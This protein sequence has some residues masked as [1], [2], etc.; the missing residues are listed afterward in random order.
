MSGLEKIVDRISK[1]SADKVGAMLGEAKQK[2]ETIKADNEKKTREECERIEKKAESQASNIADRCKASAELK[3]KQ[4]LL[5][6]KQEVLNETIDLARQKLASLS[7][8]EYTDFFVK[9]FKKHA[10]KQNAVLKLGEKD[11]GRFSDAVIAK[12][13]E[14]A[15]A[16]GSELTVSKEAA[17]IKNGFILDYGGVEEN[18][19]FDALLDQN[20]DDLLDKIKTILFA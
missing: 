11:L 7:D 4:I 19:T 13:T 14:A 17:N 16:A 6:G 18:C 5:S 8:D 1:E 15:K 20:I 12:L 9:L 2:A 3:S 10:P